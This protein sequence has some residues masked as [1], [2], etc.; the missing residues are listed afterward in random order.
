ML[1]DLLDTILLQELHKGKQVFLSGGALGFDTL[2][3]QAVLRLRKNNP[4]AKL[5]FILPCHSQ[6]L[7]WN[8][9]DKKIYQSLLKQ[10]D[11][12]FYISKDYF[13]GCMQKRNRF[14]V[15]H[16][17]VCC[18]Y[19]KSCRGGTWYT[20]SYAYDHGLNIRNLAMEF[21]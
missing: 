16:A 2:A 13:N 1:T 14:L 21:R 8:E 4:E 7:H 19:L 9:Q 10:A 15:D 12:V 17:D 11:Q 20:V 6:H 18:C 5:V 3:A